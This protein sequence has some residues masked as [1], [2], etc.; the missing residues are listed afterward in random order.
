MIKLYIGYDL[1]DGETVISYCKVEINE[2]TDVFE[3]KN[4]EKFL[5][6]SKNRDG[7]PIP[8]A[9][10]I[11]SNDEIVWGDNITKRASV[12]RVVSNFKKQP[13][14]F[15]NFSSQEERTEILNLFSDSEQNCWNSNSICN[16]NQ[17]LDFR[18]KIIQFTNA[19][20]TERSIQEQFKTITNDMNVESDSLVFCIGRPTKWGLGD[21]DELDKIIYENILRQTVIGKDYFE[22]ISNNNIRKFNSTFVTDKE[23]R[24]AFLYA[25]DQYI[26]KENGA[27]LMD[28]SRLVID[29]GSST[30]D[31]TAFKKTDDIKQSSNEA[32]HKDFGLSYLGARIIDW[33]IFDAFMESTNNILKEDFKIDIQAK[34]KLLLKCRSAKENLYTAINGLNI[35]ITDYTKEAIDNELNPELITFPN[36]LGGNLSMDLYPS[37]LLS[38]ED[39]PISEILQKYLNCPENQIE[40]VQNRSWKK[41]YE[42]FLNDKMNELQSLGY[43][44]EEII[45]TGSASKMPFIKIL[46][47][48]ISDKIFGTGR[49]SVYKDPNPGFAIAGGL[50]LIGVSKERSAKFQK[51]VDDYIKYGLRNK[52]KTFI[53][54]FAN[55]VGRIISNRIID[56]VIIPSLDEWRNNSEITVNNLME[57]IKVRCSK[58]SIEQILNSDT[59]YNKAVNT[60]TQSLLES[61]N[62]GLDVI[63]NKFDVGKEK[64]EIIKKTYGNTDV[65]IGQIELADTLA[66]PL[67]II[68]NIFAYTLLA[69]LF[70]IGI[71]IP[72]LK[73]I[74]IVIAKCAGKSIQD[75]IENIQ[76][77][78][79]DLCGER[80]IPSFL[81]G[82]AYKKAL[83][84]IE[85]KREE[86]RI[87]VSKEIESE[88]SINSYTKEFSKSI[89]LK[90]Q[91][92]IREI[93]YYIEDN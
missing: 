76:D 64:I 50:P 4:I 20:F 38:I 93:T 68:L 61:V 19:L 55:T 46:T 52:V 34:N 23:S 67:N 17:L 21:V 27:W 40:Q 79:T 25:R 31:L 84:E 35:E 75:L 1:G 12:K 74:L 88:D 59:E 18:E 32:G 62:E 36:P 5:M 42:I 29:V 51:E 81:K 66:L 71:S 43:E 3:K 13:T 90:I 77:E 58:G 91:K 86:I 30:I 2:Q 54:S 63:F 28:K 7:E 45:L 80:K 24:A 39:L 70:A 92:A 48:E 11:I 73:M 83:K 47:Q 41:M 15:F 26:S 49:V 9:Y 10:A 57:S 33:F 78:I 87:N 14:S 53:P 44:L 56:K 37:M 8:T 85:T 69:V 16:N 82:S 6:P 89:S 72:G 22:I 60:W 65:C